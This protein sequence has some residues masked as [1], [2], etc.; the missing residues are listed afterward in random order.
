M[1]MPYIGRDVARAIEKSVNES[2]RAGEW[3]IYDEYDL[4]RTPEGDRYVERTW[5]EE[6]R[7]KIG[8]VG[9]ELRYRPLVDHSDL[10]LKF[11]RLNLETPGLSSFLPDSPPI[12]YRFLFDEYDY[13]RL[14]TDENAEAARQWAWDN[15]VLGNTPGRL[16]RYG[17]ELSRRGGKPEGGP[18]D[19][20]WRFVVEWWIANRTLLLYEAATDPRGVDVSTIQKIIPSIVLLEDEPYTAVDDSPE[21]N[22][23]NALDVVA[24]Y[25]ET[26]VTDRCH[27]T[28]RRRKEGLV[29]GWGFKSLIGAMW[30]QM[31][32]LVTSDSGRRC[33]RP[34]CNRAIAIEVPNPEELEYTQWERGYRPNHYATRKDKLYCSDSCKTLASRARKRAQL[35]A[36]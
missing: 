35:K 33:Q 34:G 9:E 23:R 15:G 3:E 19:T 4:K 32:W 16:S 6:G 25:V 1:F 28:L 12:D 30:L 8:H 24:R 13:S 10:F 29:Q 17:G 22:R 2:L 20:V 26:M 7:L 21:S 36:E 31:M 14:D 11:A 27:P 5:H 18:Q